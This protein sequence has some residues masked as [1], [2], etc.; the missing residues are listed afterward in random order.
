MPVR[1]AAHAGSWYS[2]DAGELSEQLVAWLDA[3]QKTEPNARAIIAPHAGYRYSGPTAAWAYK[4]IDNSNI[5]R[6]FLLG[7]SH[8]AYL[9]GCALTQCTHYQTPLGD[10]AVDLETVAELKAA[11]EFDMMSRKVDEDEHSLEMHLPYIWQ[12]M[13]GKEFKLIPILVGAGG[14]KSERYYGKLLAPY[15]QDERNLFVV[16][17]DF[18]HWGQRFQF[19]HFDRTYSSISESIQALDRTGMDAIE[20]QDP[21]LYERY[22]SESDNTICGRHPIAVLMNA[23]AACP[24]PSAFRT[25]FV[26]YE[27]S[28]KCKSMSDSSV[29]YAAAVI[30]PI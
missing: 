18:C 5:D 23:I 22:Q 30:H 28:S 17:S 29:S 2:D 6:V 16:S 15:L 21:K 13:N 14:A 11:G 1:R 12:V 9:P 25:K 3:A 4:H 27:Q 24:S 26:H 10:I 20:T 8:H 19:T 7:P